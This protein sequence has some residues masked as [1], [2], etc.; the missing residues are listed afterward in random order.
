[1]L[2]TI[3]KLGFDEAGWWRN[4]G[5]TRS[6]GLDESNCSA[7]S[8]TVSRSQEPGYLSQ[9]CLIIFV[10]DSKVLSG[11]YSHQVQGSRKFIFKFLYVKCCV[12][13]IIIHKNWTGSFNCK[14]WLIGLSAIGGSARL[15][16]L[17]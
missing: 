3:F 16:F 6:Q 4:L 9:N 14:S 1:M 7:G 12:L 10:A 13:P 17:F 2:G 15:L 5:T 8:N 11:L